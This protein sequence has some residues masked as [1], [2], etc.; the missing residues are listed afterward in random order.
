MRHTS[1][2]KVSIIHTWF[3]SLLTITGAACVNRTTT[4]DQ[5]PSPSATSSHSVCP[6]NSCP[7]CLPVIVPC[8]CAHLSRRAASQEQSLD[9]TGGGLATSCAQPKDAVDTV[10]EAADAS[11]RPL[12]PMSGA[13]RLTTLINSFTPP[14][15]L[16]Q[17]R[18]C[19]SLAAS[20]RAFKSRTAS[21]GPR[22]TLW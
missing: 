17:K 15:Q 11:G 21:L 14:D 12:V 22:R 19:F 18:W 9:A 7:R 8:F 2:S 13:V 5:R 20:R 1:C 16:Q 10:S 4:A 6:E 3:P